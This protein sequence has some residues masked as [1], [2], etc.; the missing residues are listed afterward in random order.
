MIAVLKSVEEDVPSDEQEPRASVSGQHATVH[1]K[2]RGV[3]FVKEDQ[4][5]KL[6]PSVPSVKSLFVQ[7]TE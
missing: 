1:S 5:R 2:R 7:S 6:Q 3:M 4:L